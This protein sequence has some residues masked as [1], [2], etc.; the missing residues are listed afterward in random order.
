MVR[1]IT[2]N[3]ISLIIK[4]ILSLLLFKIITDTT[5]P[6]EYAPYGAALVF[7]G[8]MTTIGSIGFGPS[9]VRTNNYTLSKVNS[10]LSLSFIIGV[11]LSTTLYFSSKLIEE[12][13]DITGSQL[14]IELVSPI[15]VIKLIS[16]IYESIAQRELKITSIT[17]IDF[18][19]FFLFHFACQILVLKLN[20]NLIWLVFCILLEEFFKLFFYKK[21]SKIKF[22]LTLN[23]NDIKSELSFSSIL[24]IN[25]IINYFNSQIDKIFVSNQLNPTDFSGYSRVFQLINYPINI[26]GQLF[27]KIFYPIICKKF[28]LSNNKL[29]LKNI[30][31][32]FIFGLFGTIFCY[33]IGDYIEHYF[34]SGEWN[35]YM[36][37]YY[38]L[39]LLI[40]IKLI[41]RYSSVILN[42]IGKP[43]V[44]T[45]SQILFLISLT[46]GLYFS[47]DNLNSIALISVIS[48]GIS[49]L[50]S[51]LYL[52]LKK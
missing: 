13:L 37:L 28:R 7:I 12:L 17:S 25:R 35:K 40:P 38:I 43:I 46:I 18:F 31:F 49:A 20:L 5:T 24:T 34:F 29:S 30:G 4:S 10:Y 23:I 48:Y 50:T 8:L 32:I 1:K 15:I 6:S 45:I 52:V 21:I 19:S 47:H 51:I 41:D 14:Y 27:D 9:L 11:I 44:R 33:F 2:I 36:N 26:I 42:A 39:I 16:M 22:H 3:F